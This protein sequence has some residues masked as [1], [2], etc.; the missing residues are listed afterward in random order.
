MLVTAFHSFLMSNT[1]YSTAYT[2]TVL[3]INVGRGATPHEIA[4]SLANDSSIDLILIQEPYIFSD[5][6]CRI[7]K[8]H[9][10]YETFTPSDNW[11]TCPRAMSYVCKGSGLHASQLR[12]HAT[13]DIV[14]LQLQ[15]RNTAPLHIVNVYNA[16]IGAQGAG[17]AVETLLSL[18]QSTWQSAFL[19]GDF[20]LHHPNWDLLHSSPSKQSE[21]FVVW[22]EQHNFTL[23]SEVGKP[24]QNL[25][26]VLDLAFITGPQTTTTEK[27]EHMH[28][29][30]DHSPLQ[31]E[32]D[33]ST[34]LYKPEKRLQIDT[35][36]KE[37]FTS[38]LIS[39]CDSLWPLTEAPTDLELDEAASNISVAVSKA[40]NRAARRSLGQRTGQPWWNEDCKA[41]V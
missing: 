38:L 11:E 34:R 18:P 5:C 19:A 10:M 4:L 41:A 1:H 27:A 13:H 2:L 29:M 39:I 17:E 23:T 24:T 3:Q 20:N 7:T 40:F 25:G 9:P 30:S 26:N 15:A 22:L 21:A 31:S 8:H 32:I 35:L 28:V 16:P 33:W 37:L 12:P 14:F 36:D 6:T